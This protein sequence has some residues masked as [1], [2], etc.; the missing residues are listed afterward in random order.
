[1]SAK[2]PFGAYEQ[3]VTEV[4]EERLA[5]SDAAHQLRDLDPAEAALRLAQHL[6]GPI[7]GYLE[8][9]PKKERPNVQ[10]ELTNRL[11]ASLGDR[12]PITWKLQ[13]PM[14]ERWFRIAKA[15]AG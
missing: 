5:V 9:V 7:Q 15:V 11:L 13:T 2:L 4:I 10:V 14:P 3:L 6:A 1:M 8:S 12:L